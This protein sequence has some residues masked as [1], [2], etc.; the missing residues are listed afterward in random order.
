[1]TNVIIFRGIE[2]GYTVQGHVGYAVKGEDIICAAISMLTI[3]C[4]NALHLV[5]DAEPD[6]QWTD[7]HLSVRCLRP[8]IKSNVIMDVFELGMTSLME[9]YPGYIVIDKRIATFK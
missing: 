3:T 8:N 1:M 2:D 6:I 9:Q 5:A 7:A 4:A